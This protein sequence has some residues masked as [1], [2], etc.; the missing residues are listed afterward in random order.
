MGTIQLEVLKGIIEDRFGEVVDF[1]PREVIYQETIEEAAIGRGHYEPLKHYAEVHVRLEPGSLGSGLVFESACHSHQLGGSQQNLVKQYALEQTPV[2]VLVGAQLT[3]LKI[4]LL[5]GAIHEKHTQGGDLLE[6]TS[7]AIRQGLEK[8]TSKLL[9]PYYDV[10]IVVELGLMGRVLTDIQK[11][12][13]TFEN[14]EMSEMSCLITAK[15]PVA[16]F[17]DYSIE[18]LSFTK[19][20]GQIHLQVSDYAICHNPEEVIECMNYRRE[21]DRRY[22][23]A[24]IFCAKGSGFVVP[25][26]EAD[27][28]MHLES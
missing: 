2:G 17:M 21:E 14:P 8:V 26:E 6:A 20:R 19:G 4:T 18:F 10:K 12:F 7:R 22:P 27:F 13:G 25:W 1:G 5:T 3:D 24:S 11:A 9:E 15:V 28:Y 16:T 23:S